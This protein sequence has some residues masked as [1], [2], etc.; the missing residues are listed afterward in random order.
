MAEHWRRDPLPAF[1]SEFRNV[2]GLI[3][4]VCRGDLEGYSVQVLS[5][6]ALFLITRMWLVEVLTR[7]SVNECSSCLNMLFV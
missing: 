5:T 2:C 6:T 1:H 7:L 4:S 3:D